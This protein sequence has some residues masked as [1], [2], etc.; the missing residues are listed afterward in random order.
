MEYTVKVDE[1]SVSELVRQ[2]LADSLGMVLRDEADH[3]TKVLSTCLI[4]AHEYYATA[5]QHAEMVA[6]L[7]DDINEFD[8][9]YN[10]AYID[11]LIELQ[12]EEDG[13]M[14]INIDADNAMVQRFAEQGV[15]YML[16]QEMFGRPSMDDLIRWIEA[17]KALEEKE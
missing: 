11:P 7:Q 1:D 17:G 2:S 15:E 14:T 13:G 4:L 5:E 3:E 12:D 9:R 8:E 10:Q 6:E 16:L